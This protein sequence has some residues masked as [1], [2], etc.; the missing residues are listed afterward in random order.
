MKRSLTWRLGFIIIGVILATVVINAIT[1]Y[2]T[3]YDSLYQAAGVEAYGCANITTGLLDAQDI[4]DLQNGNRSEEIGEKLNWTID[5]KDIFE[6]HYVLSLDGEI[7]ALDDNLEEQGFD[8][9][10]NFYMDEKAIQA[11]TEMKHSTY[12]EVYE[13]GGMERISGYAPIFKDHDATKEIVAVSV[14]DFDANIVTERTWNVVKEGILVGSIPLL[15]AAFITIYLIRKKTKPLS[16]LIER[17]RKIADGDITEQENKISSKDEVGDLARNL[18]E[19]SIY[20]R[21]VITTI[22]EASDDLVKSANYT[23]TSMK[24]MS[25]ALGQVS[26]NMEEVAAGTFEGAEMTT[27]TSNALIN[28]AELINISSE[29]VDNSVKS[30]EYTMKTAVD[31]IQK[32]NDTAEQMN[33][34]KSSSLETKQTIEALNAYTTEIQ[35]ITRTIT[36]IAEQTNLLALNAT[37][38]A[39]RAGEHGKGFAVVANEIRKLAEQSNVEAQEVEKVI[40]KITSSIVES[41]TSIE[42]SHKKVESGE[43]TVSETGEALNSIRIAINNIA[44]EISSLSDLTHDEENISEQIV[45]HIQRLEKAN[46]T[47]A[48][49]AEG[50]SAATEESTAFIDEVSNRSSKLAEMSNNLNSIVNKF[51]L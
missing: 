36:G 19:M 12:S 42:D 34:I 47:I 4:E 48:A 33:A 7:L 6:N 39:S 24:E 49:S 3:A 27:N 22:K 5:H 1:T 18:D 50:V 15:I 35:Q 38:E 8:I 51:K 26:H 44:E 10:D 31:G 14:I 16:T 28:L 2:R 25:V 21:K 37:I 13:Y 20:L 30:A 9:G 23:S 11:L 17:T 43:R 29:K 40:S 41:V 45:Q 46:E 32:V